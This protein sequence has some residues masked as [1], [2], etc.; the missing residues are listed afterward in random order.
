MDSIT[1]CSNS[2]SDHDQHVEFGRSDAPNQV[3]RISVR[4]NY[5]APSSPITPIEEDNEERP[6]TSIHQSHQS[7]SPVMQ[8]STSRIE[9]NSSRPVTPTPTIQSS[10]PGLTESHHPPISVIGCG[11]FEY[12]LSKFH[13]LARTAGYLKKYDMIMDSLVR[14]SLAEWSPHQFPVVGLAIGALVAGLFEYH[15]GIYR[16][17]Y[18]KCLTGAIVH[19]NNV[20]MGA[21]MNTILVQGPDVIAAFIVLLLASTGLRFAPPVPDAAKSCLLL[22]LAYRKQHSETRNSPVM[23]R[24]THLILEWLRMVYTDG[25]TERHELASIYDSIFPRP[26]ALSDFQRRQ[27]YFESQCEGWN[28]ASGLAIQYTYALDCE[29]LSS[30]CKALAENDSRSDI[31]RNPNTIDLFN[32][33][34]GDF[35]EPDFIEALQVSSQW[36]GEM[37]ERYSSFQVYWLICIRGR[38]EKICVRILDKIIEAPT[39]TEGLETQSLGEM[40]KEIVAHFGGCKH[41]IHPNHVIIASLALCCRDHQLDEGNTSPSM[42]G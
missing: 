2:D 13:E 33:V 17:E 19:L 12:T 30:L 34:R 26:Q 10:R 41:K 9:S 6:D 22:L 23:E 8:E 11:G 15:H 4:N 24:Y 38:T 40:G 42:T 16:Y 21:V 7:Q 14:C 36:D 20:I 27:L 39:I 3:S 29:R 18:K 35:N 31:R 32:V 1:A 5:T 37:R 25:P 28:S